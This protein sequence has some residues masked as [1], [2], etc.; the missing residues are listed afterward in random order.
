MSDEARNKHLDWLDDCAKEQMNEC[1]HL[2]YYNTDDYCYDCEKPDCDVSL[3]V[4]VAEDML[5][6]HA[7]LKQWQS[8]AVDSLLFWLEGEDDIDFSIH[9][10]RLLRELCNC[11]NELPPCSIC[12]RLAL[13]TTE[14]QDISGER[15]LLRE[16][17][18]ETVMPMIGLLL[19][20]WEDLPNDVKSDPELSA[21]KKSINNIRM[22]MEGE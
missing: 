12:E 17:Q 6:E 8:K 16:E 18:A 2:W 9:A 13:L 3:G 14:E 19:D 11:E 4:Y 15:E 5:N 22:A 10:D 7:A 21:L 1:E 20:R